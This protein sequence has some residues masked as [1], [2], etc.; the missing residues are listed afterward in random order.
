MKRN[1]RRV[2]LALLAALVLLVAVLVGRT[3]MFTSVQIDTPPSTLAVDAGE[4]AERLAAASRFRTL[5]I[6]AAGSEGA[7][8]FAAMHDWLVETYPRFHRTLKR[9]SVD[10]INLL[11]TWPGSD[12]SLAPVLF[13]AHQDV[14]PVEA[15]TEEDWTHPPFAGRIAPCGDEEGDC[16]WGRGTIDMKAAMIGL[17]EG[18]ER[19]L[20][21]GYAPTRTLMFAFAVDEEVGG[22]GAEAMTALLDARGVRFEWT[23]D[24][25]LLIT[26]GLMPGMQ[27][28]IALIGLSEK[29]YTTLELI[30]HSEGGHSSMPPAV[31]AVGRLARAIDRL[32]SD[33]FPRAIDGA[34]AEMFDRVGPE[35]GF[36]QRLAFANR[37]LL[38][39]VIVGQ[40]AKGNSTNALLH[41]TQAP[42]MLAGSMQE[43]VMPQKARAVINYR[44]HPRDSVASVVERV[45]RVVDDPQVTV[46]K[47]EGAIHMDPAKV[48]DADAEGHRIVERAIRASF[49][50]ALVASGLF[51]AATDTRHFGRLAK[52]SYRFHPIR[53]KPTDGKRIHGTDERL[54]MADIPG[55][56][57]FYHQTLKAAG[58]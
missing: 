49:P 33:P 25:G 46:Q 48:S 27:R 29:G 11:F 19:L 40:L 51:V 37:W 8:P 10:D 44:I 38:E 1:I 54:R 5:S 16:V 30:A 22:A 9:E 39:P 32:Q 4:V 47:L 35:M 2:A 43:N 12:P 20:G 34:V 53:M 36:G 18:V 57:R 17:F 14:V 3:L 15:G 23:L 24:E 58:Q 45:T 7:A 28:P 26:D 56:V 31:T 52:N 42:T 55:L 50:E 21:E 13:I 6:G 41:T